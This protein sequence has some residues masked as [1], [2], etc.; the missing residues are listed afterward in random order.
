MIMRYIT[1]V[2]FI[3]AIH[4]M[5]FIIFHPLDNFLE[6]IKKSN[7]TPVKKFK[8]P[9]TSAQEVGWNTDP[10]VRVFKKAFVLLNNNYLSPEPQ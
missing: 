1:L 5:T 6:V 4:V 8:F 10:L 9:Q 7:E 3:H 2:W